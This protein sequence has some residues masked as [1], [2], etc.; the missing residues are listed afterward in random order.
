MHA[1][2]DHANV[3]VFGREAAGGFDAVEF[4]HGDVH[5]DDIGP[6]AGCELDGFAA[7]AGFA[8]DF[9]VRLGA[10]KHAKTLPHHG[11][12]VS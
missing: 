4:R 5:H 11:V 6:Q 1:Q 3:R 9:E 8:D 2:G 7:V 10:Q 12:I